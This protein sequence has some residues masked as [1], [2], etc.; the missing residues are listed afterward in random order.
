MDWITTHT[1][2]IPPESTHMDDLVDI[3]LSTNI[4]NADQLF[5][6]TREISYSSIV[7]RHFDVFIR[8]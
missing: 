8:I 2:I 6:Y 5:K 1:D 7:H 3:I 4:P